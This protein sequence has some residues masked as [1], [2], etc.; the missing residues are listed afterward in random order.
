M[1]KKR[2]ILL[3]IYAATLFVMCILVVPFTSLSKHMTY[4]GEIWSHQKYYTVDLTR[5]LIQI[6]AITV[7]FAVIYLLTDKKS[8]GKNK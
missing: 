3:I 1:N 6:F 4:Y 8:G 5:L 2:K 7:I